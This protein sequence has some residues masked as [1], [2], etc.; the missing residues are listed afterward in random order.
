MNNFT[1]AFRWKDMLSWYMPN[2]FRLKTTSRSCHYL[3]LYPL[4]LLNILRSINSNKNNN[5]KQS[6]RFIFFR[7]LL[8]LFKDG[9]QNVLQYWITTRQKWVVYSFFFFFIR[10]LNFVRAERRHSMSSLAAR[11]CDGIICGR[12]IYYERQPHSTL[13]QLM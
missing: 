3:R 12:L 9:K 1:I 6:R 11:Q 7:S 2:N 8:F 5:R 13:I 10:S 4:P